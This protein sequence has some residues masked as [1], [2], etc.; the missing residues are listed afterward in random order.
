MIPSQILGTSPAAGL[1]P[2]IV[3][4]IVEVIVVVLVLNKMISN[5]K[6]KG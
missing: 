5:A 4:I 2:G 3:G 1:I 6:A